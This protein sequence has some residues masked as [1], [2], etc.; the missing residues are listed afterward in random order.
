MMQVI[1]FDFDGVIAESS[2]IKTEAF[3]ELFEEFGNSIVT[4]VIKHHTDNGGITRYKKIRYYYSEYLGK[5][6]TDEE[7]HKITDIFSDI[8][9]KKVINAPFVPGI[10]EFIESHYNKSDMY[11]ISGTPQFELDMI[12]G[13]K[14]LKKYFKEVY[15]TTVNTTKTDIMNMIVNNNK[16]HKSQV[17]YIGDCLSD[18]YDAKRAHIPFIGRII[19]NK[20]IFPSNTKTIN[21]FIGVDF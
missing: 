5:E 19:D 7:L 13:E 11:I 15:G 2:N 12:I 10:L 8:V 4:K 16:Y 1:F 9:L 14:K 6:L 18:Y 17:V 20:S 3:V 21:N